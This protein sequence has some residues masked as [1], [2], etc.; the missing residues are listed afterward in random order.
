ML[1]KLFL[2]VV[3]LTFL[4]L[5]IQGQ[6]LTEK[7]FELAK[8]LDYGKLTRDYLA[9][10]NGTVP[11]FD[12]IENGYHDEKQSVKTQFKIKIS[13][14]KTYFSSAMANLALGNHSV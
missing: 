2:R 8:T 13:I 3:C 14:Y 4:V 6:A 12:I 7:D 9:K 11:K 10:N 1:S 5:E